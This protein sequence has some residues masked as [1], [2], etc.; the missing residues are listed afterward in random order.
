[1]ARAALAAVLLDELLLGHRRAV[2][3]A[4]ARGEL[5]RLRPEAGDEHGRR[6][7]RQRVRARVLH[8]V[9]AAAVALVAALPEQPHHLD[10][11]LEHL[12]AHV[13]LGPLVAEALLVE[14]LAADAA[15]QHY[16]VEP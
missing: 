11:L 5:D 12:Q 6:L 14:R 8:R 16:T 7:V 9:V 2:A 1:R 3:V 15:E 10:R 13:G 4:D